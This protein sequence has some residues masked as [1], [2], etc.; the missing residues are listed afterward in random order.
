MQQ[1]APAVT[2]N[3]MQNMREMIELF[4]VMQPQNV[5]PPVD[6]MSVLRNVIELQQ[7]MKPDTDEAP[8]RGGAGTND[9]ILAMIN[10]FG[11][12]FAGALGQNMGQPVPVEMPGSYPDPLAIEHQPPATPESKTESDDMNAIAAMK[13]KMGLGW[14]VDQCKAGGFPETYAEVIIDSVPADTL[15]ELLAAPSPLAVLAAVNPAVNDNAE[16][17]TSLLA[18]CKNILN[19]PPEPA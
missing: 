7:L 5:A 12:L 14:L 9:L 2:V 3:P 16:W 6:Q 13:L 19:A 4:K 8:V 17:F 1:A 18:E 15:K 10:K 11:P